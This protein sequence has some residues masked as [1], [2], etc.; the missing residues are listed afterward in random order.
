MALLDGYSREAISSMAASLERF[1][2]YY[3]LVICLKN[4]IAYEQFGEAWK[5]VAKQ[6][7][8][9]LGAFLFVYLLEGGKPLTPLINDQKPTLQG[10]SRGKILTWA[11]FRNEVIHNGYIPTNEEV[12]EYGNLVYQ[13]VYR[14]IAELKRS[15]AES[16]QRATFHHLTR[17]RSVA[18]GGPV[19]TMSVPTL[20][21]LTRADAPAGHLRNGLGGLEKYRRWLYRS[22]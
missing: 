22:E 19:A 14:V 13:F 15:S 12:L 9:Q 11:A 8:R 3:I 10:R 2:E 5:P 18:N 4:D 7:E 6:S 1:F 20:I 16:M 21:S 17:G